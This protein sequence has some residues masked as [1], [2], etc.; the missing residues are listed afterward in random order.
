[1]QQY[2]KK[3]VKF[4][5]GANVNTIRIALASSYSAA[6][7][8]APVW[9]SSPH[10]QKLNKDLNIAIRAVTGCLKPT[11][12][13]DLDLLTGF[14]SPDIQRD[15]CARME[16]IKQETNETHSLFGQHPAETASCV[17]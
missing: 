16:N 13:E 4:K 14:A 6:E 12:V 1:M 7:Y 3:A 2:I 10:D 5:W 11:N 17:V 8:A 15:V 9:A